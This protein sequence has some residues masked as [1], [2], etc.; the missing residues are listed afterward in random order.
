ML[1]ELNAKTGWDVPMHV[2]AVRWIG[3]HNRIMRSALFFF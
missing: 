3:V 1:V 2:D